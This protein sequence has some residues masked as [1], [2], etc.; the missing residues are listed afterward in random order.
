MF[1]AVLA[2]HILIALLTALLVGALLIAF[3][4]RKQGLAGFALV[5]FVLGLIV[6]TGGIWLMPFGPI[7]IKAYPFPFILTGLVLALSAASLAGGRPR[8]A[9][10]AGPA[11]SGNRSELGP[12]AVVFWM[13]VALLALMIAARFLRI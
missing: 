9:A 4:R 10:V 2:A 8:R 1:S 3:F 6:W 12:L 5:F 13:L 11:A 7:V